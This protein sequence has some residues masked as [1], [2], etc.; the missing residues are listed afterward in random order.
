M[1]NYRLLVL[2]SLLIVIPIGF[3]SKFYRGPFDWWVNDYTGGIWYEIFWMLVAVVIQPRF[4]AKW[5][6]L[7]VFS[8]TSFLEFLQLWHGPFLE[9]IRSTFLGRTLI[10]SSFSWWDFPYYVIGCLWGWL[11]LMFLHKI[12]QFKR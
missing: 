9:L 4:D 3:A 10:G 2:I 12:S 5:V 6:G 1:R 8:V 7:I 11:W